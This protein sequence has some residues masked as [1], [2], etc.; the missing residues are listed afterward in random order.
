ML[1]LP[2]VIPRHET[3][4]RGKVF[5]STPAERLRSVTITNPAQICGDSGETRVQ[6]NTIRSNRAV[7]IHTGF[8]L[9]SSVQRRG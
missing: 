8:V 4:T 5:S 2:K 3:S 1:L 9:R 6:Q 7:S